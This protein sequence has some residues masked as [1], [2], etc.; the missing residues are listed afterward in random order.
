MEAS[1]WFIPYS[2]REARTLVSRAGKRKAERRSVDR[3]K[4]M[5]KKSNWGKKKSRTLSSSPRQDGGEPDPRR[6][7]R[8]LWVNQSLEMF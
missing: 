7:D 1:S 4:D 2:Q 3:E 8:V 6:A 5:K